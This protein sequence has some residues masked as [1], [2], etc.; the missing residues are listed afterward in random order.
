V[1]ARAEALLPLSVPAAVAAVAYEQ[2]EIGAASLA[3][4]E[5]DDEAEALHGFRL[6]VRRLRSLLRAYQPWLGK[7]A[8]EKVQ[9][10]LRRLGRS[11][12]E[13]RDAEVRL[14][15]I[16]RERKALLREERRGSRRAVRRLKAAREKGYGTAKGRVQKDYTR[17]AQRLVRR[18]EKLEQ[19]EP[20]LAEVIPPLVRRQ[21]AE[22]EV[23]L[24]A[25]RDGEDRE[26]AHGARI[27]GKRLRYL[28][29]PIAKESSETRLLL[30][31]LKALHGL[32]GKINDLYLV[33]ET[34]DQE[35]AWLA[36]AEARRLRK[37]ADQPAENGDGPPSNRSEALV[38][39][40]ALA[41]LARSQKKSLFA[42]LERRWLG[43][44][45]RRFFRD[46]EALAQALWENAADKTPLSPERE[47]ADGARAAGVAAPERSPVRAS[48]RRKPAQQNLL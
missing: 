23:R 35:I 34:L 21:A 1:S 15:W 3:A 47:A 16:A 26:G 20:S 2:L 10:S 8:G 5:G 25:V 37:L 27:A 4:I 48:R 39:V 28:I 42:E 6:A 11:T 41:A 40:E 31:R 45:G 13:G 32:L 7:T 14:A 24:A 44:R 29:E 22:L 19:V 38:G 30:D 33:L 43:G 46:T 12:N 18:L 9:R 36:R 17:A